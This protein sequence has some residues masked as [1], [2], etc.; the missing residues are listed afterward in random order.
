MKRIIFALTVLMNTAVLNAQTL[1]PSN[2][3]RATNGSLLLQG[4][5]SSGVATQSVEV[6]NVGHIF[7]RSASFNGA[8][9]VSISGNLNVY[10]NTNLGSS[11]KATTISGQSTTI[12]T[13]YTDIN[14]VVTTF[15]A[16][17]TKTTISKNGIS[18]AG[19]ITGA[20]MYTQGLDVGN[21]IINLK[22]AVS[23][24]ASASSVT[25]LTNRVTATEAD[26]VNLQNNK[27]DKTQVALDI[28]KAKDEAIKTSND[29]TD[30]KFTSLDNKVNT[31][32]AH[33]DKR[34]GATDTKVAD[35]T[36]TVESNKAE[37]KAYTDAESIRAINAENAL[38][39]RIDKEAERAR[40]AERELR[41]DLSLESRRARLAE[42]AITNEMMGIAAMSAAMSAA[43]GSQIYNSQKRG[44][45]SFGT[46][47]YGNAAAVSAG[48]SYFVSP[49]AKIS[50][51][52]A[53]GSN[54]RAA[55][56]GLGFSFGF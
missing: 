24:K 42:G 30:S 6:T 22:D 48:F 1:I 11:A 56:A 29:Y 32:V 16:D 52:V 47:F 26:I 19:A 17:G 5:N 20:K 40:E 13:S 7:A 53:S 51:N 27:A 44:N 23:L 28:K 39:N 12:K 3:V 36:K 18:T 33:L 49:N 54:T 41:T 4:T 2:I 45:L 14:S 46:G 8:D 10:G 55:A 37:A 31:E 38:G 9:G 21:D 35:L 15:N 34:I 50:A 25:N 43:N